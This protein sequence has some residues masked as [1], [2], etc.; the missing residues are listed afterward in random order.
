[1]SCEG[2]GG[3]KSAD[4]EGEGRG[5]KHGMEPMPMPHLKGSV[6][7][8]EM[9]WREGDD[10]NAQA[11]HPLRPHWWL[12]PNTGPAMNCRSTK[13]FLTANA[14]GGE[15]RVAVVVVVERMLEG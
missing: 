15:C 7:S 4:W 11:L 2:Q 14:S 6:G 5:G 10:A 8:L 1:M 13:L 3:E 12:R 9:W